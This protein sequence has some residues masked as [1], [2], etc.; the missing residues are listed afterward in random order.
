MITFCMRDISPKLCFCNFV[1]RPYCKLLYSLS[2]PS[3]VVRPCP[4]LFKLPAQSEQESA[5]NSSDAG[6]WT[7]KQFTST[8]STE[9]TPMN[10]SSLPYRSIF[11]VL[12]LDMVLIYDTYHKHPLAMA[13]GIHYAGL[14][15]ATWT[16]DGR[17]LLISSTDGYVSIM[18]FEM[19]ELGD[20]YIA[21]SSPSS[22]LLSS[23]E[24]EDPPAHEMHTANEDDSVSK[25]IICPNSSA[26]LTSPPAQP[27]SAGLDSND[28]SS[29]RPIIEKLSAETSA[30]P[31]KKKR[32][33]IAPTLIS[34]SS[35]D[36]CKHATDNISVGSNYDIEA[37]KDKQIDS[38]PK[39]RSTA[40]EIV[41]KNERE[42]KLKADNNEEWNELTPGQTGNVE[43]QKKEKTK[44]RIQPTLLN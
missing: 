31:T 24:H 9:E 33:R 26:Q 14:T 42:Q 22:S 27:I 21:P 36:T 2:Q 6:S 28:A 18:S 39:E 23:A 38:T 4:I 20:E 41:E 1:C 5:T 15:D 16:S 32:R 10:Y 8:S 34:A 29:Q 25:S 40:K 35:P 30:L 13:R 17:H 19:G 7:S 11:A 12:T 44:K 3:V 37:S 43:P